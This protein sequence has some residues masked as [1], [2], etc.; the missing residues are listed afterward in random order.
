[1]SQKKENNLPAIIF[2]NTDCQLKITHWLKLIEFDNLTDTNIFSRVKRRH[3]LFKT[4]EKAKKKLGIMLKLMGISSN[5]TCIIKN[6]DSKDSFDIEFTELGKIGRLRIHFGD[7]FDFCDELTLTLDN[8]SRTYE[9]FFDKTEKP[10]YIILYHYTKT[11]PTTGNSY[12]RFFSKYRIT[13]MT[14]IGDET[15]HIDLTKPGNCKDRTMKLANEDKLV[16]YLM[17][18]H[19]PIEIDIIYRKLCEIT[20]LNPTICP[21][22]TLESKNNNTEITTNLLRLEYGHLKKFIVTKDGYTI[23]VESDGTWNIHPP[24]NSDHKNTKQKEEIIP[25]KTVEKVLNFH[26]GI[27]KRQK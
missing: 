6:Y 17:G 24:L 20:N 2:E 1:M 14:K 10:P 21:S 16:E 13:L 8:L 18:Y 22:L 4:A 26:K 5:E 19:H 12:Y 25:S 15:L 9:C 27:Q 3:I 11:D 23:K 7:G